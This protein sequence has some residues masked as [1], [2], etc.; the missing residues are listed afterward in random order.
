[1]SAKK[2]KKITKSHYNAA[3]KQALTYIKENHP[4]FQAVSDRLGLSSNSSFNAFVTDI[5]VNTASKTQKSC[6]LLDRFVNLLG[7]L[8]DENL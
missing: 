7:Q 3:E 2:V 5:F 8:A 1:M 6:L 4:E